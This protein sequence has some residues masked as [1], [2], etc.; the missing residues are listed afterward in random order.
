MESPKAI[1]GGLES[2]NVPSRAL[3]KLPWDLE[4]S[5]RPEE[6]EAVVLPMV[7]REFGIITAVTPG[8]VGHCL[9]LGS[10]FTLLGQTQETSVAT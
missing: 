5:Q 1:L 8:Q 3:T 10:H 4:R 6:L 2:V 9:F 7:K